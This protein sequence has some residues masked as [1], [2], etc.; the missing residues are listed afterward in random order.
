MVVMALEKSYPQLRERQKKLVEV[1]LSPWDTRSG[2]RWEVGLQLEL[3]PLG[4]KAMVHRG[5][6]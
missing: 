3:P 1:P 6:G 5:Q 2:N 4:M